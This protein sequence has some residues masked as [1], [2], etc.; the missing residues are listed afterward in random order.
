MSIKEQKTPEQNFA[1]S[2]QKLCIKYGYENCSFVGEDKNKKMIG[3]FCA[4]KERTRIFA[5]ELMRSA[6][7]VSRLYQAARE[8]LFKMMDK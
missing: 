2:L 4:E 7:N 6:F 3:F 1:S 5:D 8:Q